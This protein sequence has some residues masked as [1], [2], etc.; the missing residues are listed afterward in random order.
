M[1]AH[2]FLIAFLPNKHILLVK[3]VRRMR[4]RFQQILAGNTNSVNRLLKLKKHTLSAI[5]KVLLT[6]LKDLKKI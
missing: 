4:L 1:E 6:N 2:L 5:S 3:S